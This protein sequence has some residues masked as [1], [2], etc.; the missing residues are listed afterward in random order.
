[1]SINQ[2]KRTTHSIL[3]LLL[4]G[5]SQGL[6]D[7]N[8]D[9]P[10]LSRYESFITDNMVYSYNYPCDIKTKDSTYYFEILVLNPK[11]TC[12][13]RQVL[14]LQE[15]PKGLVLKTSC[16]SAILNPKFGIDPFISIYCDSSS[17]SIIHAGGD[18]NWEMSTSF[19]FRPEL[20]DWFLTTI[21]SRNDVTYSG[22]DSSSIFGPLLY[23]V[24][25]S[26]KDFGV[27][28]F[29]DFSVTK[30]IQLCAEP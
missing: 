5:C 9:T 24:V 18:D 7:R 2:L 25:L 20:N 13:S 3:I 6:N 11:D 29:S 17:F 4:I 22:C 27:I 30:A 28:K 26:E 16:D 15:T 1:M 14:I 21:N 12:K 19:E 10:D 8:E 23:M